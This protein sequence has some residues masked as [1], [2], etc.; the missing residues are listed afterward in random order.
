MGPE[1]PHTQDMEEDT[2]SGEQDRQHGRKDWEHEKKTQLDPAQVWIV[3]MEKRSLQSEGGT[4]ALLQDPQDDP[5]QRKVSVDWT[6][7]T[8]GV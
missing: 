3:N 1:Y 5:G 6:K 7:E 2:D 4:C 8:P